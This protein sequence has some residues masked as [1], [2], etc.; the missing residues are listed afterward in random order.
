MKRKL[1]TY[2]TFNKKERN[3]ILLLSFLLI[4]LI[5]FYQFTHLLKTETKTDFSDF[6]KAIQE[7]KYADDISKLKAKDSLFHF[8]PNT[9]ND[10]GWLA[11]GLSKGKLQ[12]LRN[13][14]KSGGYFKK[15]QDLQRCYAFGDEFYNTI[16]EYVS[17]PEIDKL[18]N[19]NKDPKANSHQPTTI[20]QMIELNQADSLQL[21]SI[22]GIGPFYSKQILKYRKQL[23][24]FLNYNQFSEIWGL[25]KLDVESL[26]KQTIIDT[27]YIRKINI[28]LVTIETFRKHPYINYKEAK[29]IVNFKNQHGDFSSVKDIQKIKPISPEI[30]RKIAPYLKTDD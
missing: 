8:N 27:F 24:G 4:I 10:K 21:I 2:F 13:Y 17:I 15:K 12:A 9:L 6:E 19:S 29:M 5:I 26:Q 23:G 18:Q 20:V 11:L 30:F 16:K 1:K 7:L 25:D 22:K 14:Q 3:G 28:N